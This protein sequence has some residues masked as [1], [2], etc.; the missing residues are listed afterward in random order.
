MTQAL[1]R[2]YSS[3]GSDSINTAVQDMEL[4][5]RD[6]LNHFQTRIGERVGRP[7]F[8]SIIHNLMFNPGDDRTEALV[9]QDATRIVSEDPRVELLELEPIISL[10]ANRIELRIKLKAV[11]FDME[12]WFIVTFSQSL[13]V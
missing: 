13:V 12:D 4:I 10:D 2:G 3:T 6:L 1:Y 11:E 9:V 5:K 8:G 7:G